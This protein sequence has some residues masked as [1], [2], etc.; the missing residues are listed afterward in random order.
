[1]NDSDLRSLI[2][3]LHARL[4][5]SQSLNDEDRRLLGVALQDIE[6][7]LASGAVS[8]PPSASGLEALAVKFEADHPAFAETLRRLVDAL[9]K[10]GI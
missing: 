8:P 4:G 1:M 2:T 9:G 3:Q 5:S 10:A 7:V 6:N